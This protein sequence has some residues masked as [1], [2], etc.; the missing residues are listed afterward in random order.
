MSEQR[1]AQLR[2]L[3]GLRV[4]LALA[5]GSRIDDCQLVSAGRS[6]MR[7]VWIHSNGFDVFIQRADVLDVWEPAA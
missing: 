1:T 6:G 4:S 3:E 2:A 7:T 5:D